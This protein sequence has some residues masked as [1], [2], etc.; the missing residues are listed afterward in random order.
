MSRKTML[1]EAA[2]PSVTGQPKTLRQMLLDTTTANPNLPALVSMCQS[3]TSFPFHASARSTEDFLT[4]TYQELDERAEKVASSIFA[5]GLRSGMRLAVCLPNGVEWALLFWASV[6]IGAIFVP[7]DER[8]V[9]RKDEIHHYLEVVTPSA[10]VLASQANARMLLDKNLGVL[11]TI[12]MKIILE[13]A[14]TPLTGWG[15]FD[16]LFANEARANILDSAYRSVSHGWGADYC[17]SNSLGSIGSQSSGSQGTES[18]M[19]A[20]LYICFTSGTSGLPKACP[21]SNKNS[22]AQAMAGKV[23][24]WAT[25]VAGNA[26]DSKNQKHLIVSHAP[27]SHSMGI[28]QHDRSVDQRGHGGRTFPGFRG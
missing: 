13:P 24:T 18:E 5:R 26:D 16:D 8:A 4:W 27:P 11:E 14:Q 15:S 10:L 21:L 1:A 20:I 7:L 22:W 6:K 25:A 2:G 9:P 28:S 12:P 23:S 19:N 3:T 17:S